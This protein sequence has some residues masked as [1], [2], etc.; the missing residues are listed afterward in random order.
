MINMS[1]Y[2][3]NAWNV[4]RVDVIAVH[5]QI[6]PTETAQEPRLEHIVLRKRRCEAEL[7][8]AFLPL[9]CLRIYR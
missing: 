2:V 7:S 9:V 3:F 5:I 1:Q 8:P 6:L 4:P